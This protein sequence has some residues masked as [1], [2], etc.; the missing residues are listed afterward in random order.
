MSIRVG[1][2]P[3]ART[4]GFIPP[5]VCPFS[6]DFEDDTVGEVPADWEEFKAT[7]RTRDDQAKTGDQSA[8]LDGAS[9]HGYRDAPCLTEEARVVEYARIQGG[10][11]T[12][13]YYLMGADVGGVISNVTAIIGRSHFRYYDLISWKD[14]PN[15][16]SPAA[17]TWYKFDIRCDAEFGTWKVVI[18]TADSGWLKGQQYPA[19][20]NRLQTYTALTYAPTYAWIDD[21]DWT[22]PEKRLVFSD[23]FETWA[24][25][26]NY[27]T[28]TVEQSDEQ[29]HGGSYSLKKDT[30]NDPHGGWKALGETLGRGI[31][32]S[33]WFYRPTGWAG[34]SA[35]RISLC[36][37][38]FDGYGFYTQHPTG[39]LVIE[40]RTA[41]VASAIGAALAFDAPDDAW[42]KFVFYIGVTG[43][44]S[45]FIYNA[46]GTYMASIVDRKDTSYTSFDRVVIHGGYEFYVDDLKVHEL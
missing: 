6:Q 29:A 27:L 8:R 15:S 20:L 19:G 10:A 17:N 40:K 1:L 38:D 26:T 25:W 33:G 44:L 30:A 28:G 46:A 35:D 34:G 39:N 23:D 2:R 24:G 11:E 13:A 14:I 37:G 22:I 36:N 42:Y 41:G 3:M 5:I 7:F 16:A 21:V 18:N 12:R 32:L 45:V 9:S 43:Q 4:L 31:V